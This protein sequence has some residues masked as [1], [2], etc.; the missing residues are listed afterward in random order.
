[1][2]KKGERICPVCGKK[3]LL[4]APSNRDADG[5]DIIEGYPPAA[6]A[7][8]TKWSIMPYTVYPHRE[9]NMVTGRG[10]V[11]SYVSSNF[12]QQNLNLDGFQLYNTR[13]VF[14]CEECSSRLSLNFNPGGLMDI[15]LVMMII[16]VPLFAVGV[17]SPSFFAFWWVIVPLALF[18]AVF[19]GWV[20]CMVWAKLYLSNFVPVDEYDALIIPTTELTLSPQGLKKKFLHESNI[21]TVQLSQQT[22]HLYLANKTDKVLAFSVCGTDGEQKRFVSLLERSGAES[23]DLTFEGKSAGLSRVEGFSYPEIDEEK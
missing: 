13:L 18:G 6:N 16:V 20:G 8:R 9:H 21:F 14:F 7:V 23:L 5:I 2:Q 17:F 22:F 4:R 10:G 1:M 11:P 12:I 19:F 15:L 3:L